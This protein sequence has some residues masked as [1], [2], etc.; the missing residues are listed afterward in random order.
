VVSLALPIRPAPVISGPSAPAT[1]EASPIQQ[2]MAYTGPAP[3]AAAEVMV[4]TNHH[5]RSTHLDALSHQAIDGL[6]YRGR[7]FADGVTA[8]GARHASTTIFAT[9]VVTRGILLDLAADGPLPAGHPG[10]GQDLDAAEEREG[11]TLE[12]GDALV[13]RGGWR[14]ADDPPRPG[15]TTDAVRWM[16]RRGVSLY[17]GDIGSVLPPLNPGEPSPLHKVALVM[18]G[19]PLIDAGNVDDLAAVCAEL[20]PY[21]FLLTIAP[22]RIHGLTGVP[23]NP[24]A[25]L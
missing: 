7:L 2:V 10:T 9:G 14:M 13:V 1:T 8:A 21:S 15:I 17:A 12:S 3:Q 18:L 6:V 4:V 24:L 23:V 11:V 22:P 25:I 5:P 16:D 19:M 20:S